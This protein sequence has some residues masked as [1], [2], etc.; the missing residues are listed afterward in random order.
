MVGQ[1][2]MNNSANSPAL[3]LKDLV[4]N[5]VLLM[6]PKAVAKG[7]DLQAQVPAA[8][9][10][11]RGTALG[12]NRVL[13]NLVHNAIK[14]SHSGQ[15]VTVRAMAAPPYAL[16]QVVDRGVGMTQEQMALLFRGQGTPGTEGEASYGLGLNICRQLVEQMDGQLTVESRLGEGTVMTVK[17]PLV[18]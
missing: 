13:D 12:L 11:V 2:S 15:P 7:I 4:N 1:A 5:C 16:L 17:L 18:A 10:K 14:F 9:L 6:G 8:P 3:E